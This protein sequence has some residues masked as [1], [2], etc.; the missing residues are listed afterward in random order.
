ML[1]IA[2]L[3]GR[4]V[5][6]A[7]Q[8]GED[9]FWPFWVSRPPAV[10]GEGAS[11]SWTGLG[12]L[13]FAR[14][15]VAPE[16]GLPERLGGFRP[17]YLQRVEAGGRVA[18]AH[19]LYPLAT[20]RSSQSGTATWSF[21]NLITYR[22]V[23]GAGVGG[24]QATA[25]DAWPF[26]FS[27]RTGD[28]ETDYRAVFPLGGEMRNRFGQD[29]LRF[30][31]FPLYGRFEKG[32]MVTTTTPWPIIKTV[33]GDGHRGFEV[34]PVYGQRRKEGSYA[35]R[36]ALW[37]LLY[38]NRRVDADGRA[39]R[40]LGVLPFYAS[41]RMPGYV[42]ETWA[43]PFFGYVERT[44]PYVYRADHYFWPFLVRGRGDDRRVDR[45]A[46]FYTRSTIK[47]TEKTWILWP[48][49]R[50]ARWRDGAIDQTRTQ[51]LYALYHDSLQRSVANPE[52]TA[53][54]TH[55]WPL[56]SYWDNGAGRRQVQALSPF[57]VFLPH[58]ETVRQAWSPLFALY[59]YDRAAD[60]AVR[61]ALLWDGVTYRR[62]AGTDGTEFHLGPLLGVTGRGDARRIAFGRGLFGLKREPG[63]GRWRP[64]F[65][66]F[67]GGDGSRTTR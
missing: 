5:D 29:R 21:F 27:R 49:W 39:S 11:R 54:K 44:D 56:F 34:W 43:W 8:A 36:F 13:V 16:G 40:S 42:S 4:A 35:E 23:A 57:E 38:D 26:Y 62:G 55:V 3:G 2:L 60:G 14:D 41:D 66:E 28:P 24:S 30:A 50:Q 45:W 10:A 47:G 9:N 15:G 33:S 59:R 53:R 7:G 52:S 17:F 67:P 12:P 18:E 1:G 48:L 58:N 51:V 19:V 25:F 64:F 31:L 61:H 32:G 20:Y 22:E 46:P 6:G 63:G 65:G 37:P